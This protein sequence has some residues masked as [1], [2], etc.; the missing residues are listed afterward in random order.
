MTQ[1][2]ET[3]QKM[4]GM[5]EGELE[6]VHAARGGQAESVRNTQALAAISHNVPADVENMTLEEARDALR[7][8]RAS[9][10]KTPAAEREARYCELCRELPDVLQGFWDQLSP[11]KQAEVLVEGERFV[12]SVRAAAGA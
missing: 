8:I 5:I 11:E 10:Q 3:S 9:V 4:V 7:N 2:L 1:G 12:A 6:R